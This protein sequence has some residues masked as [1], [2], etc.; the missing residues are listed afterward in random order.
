MHYVGRLILLITG[1]NSNICELD[2]AGEKMFQ[3]GGI[4]GISEWIGG[5]RRIHFPA[6][7]VLR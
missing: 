2:A 3:P 4:I 1:K 5:S 7:S 6:L